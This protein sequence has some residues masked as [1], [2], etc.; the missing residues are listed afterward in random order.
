MDVAGDVNGG[1]PFGFSEGALDLGATST[2]AAVG[3]QAT[4]GEAGLGAERAGQYQFGAHI[5]HAFHAAGAIVA[6][7]DAA[8]TSLFGGFAQHADGAIL[9]QFLFNI[10]NMHRGYIRE[11][12]ITGAMFVV[13]EQQNT[14]ASHDL[15]LVSGTLTTGMA[16]S[17]YCFR[18]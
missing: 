16:T 14:F 7:V 5:L 6:T 1:L 9:N 3:A 10:V 13:A 8:P 15:A 4:D 11:C 2:G 18:L 12:H 17:R